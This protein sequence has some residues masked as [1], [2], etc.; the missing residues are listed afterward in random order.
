[1]RYRRERRNTLSLPVMMTDLMKA[2]W[3][4]IARRTLR[5]AQNKC[6]PAEYQRMVERRPWRLQDLDLG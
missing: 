5:V 6:S 4:T 2:S 1:M 3:E